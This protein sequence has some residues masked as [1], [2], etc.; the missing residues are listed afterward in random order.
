MGERKIEKTYCRMCGTICGIDVHVEDGKVVEIEGMEEHVA[1]R[2]RTCIKGSSGATWINLPQRLKKPLK[3]TENGFVEIE[4]EQA[5]DEIAER[6][7]AIQEQYGKRAI[8]VWKGEGIGFCQQEEL[9]RRFIHAIGSPNYFSNDTQCYAGRY[10]GF[11]LVYGTWPAADYD[12]SKLIVNWGT[13]APV[14]HSDWTQQMNKARANGGKFV[15]IDTKYNESARI[16]DLYLQPKPGTDGAL[17]WGVIRELIVRDAVNHDFI[18]KYTV[19]YEDLKAYAQSF[20]PEFVEAETGIKQEQLFALVELFI[21]QAP[22]I[23]SWVG[24][25]L[26]HQENGVNNT[27]V[28]TYIDALMGAIDI[29]GGMLCTEGFGPSHLELNDEIPLKHLEPIGADKHPVIYDMRGECDTLTLMDAI[30]TEKP[31]PMKGLILSAANPVLTNARAD[32][33]IDAFKQLDLLVVKDIM[34]TETAE[35]ADYV[36]P[37]ASYLE[38]EELHYQSTF[39]C[40]TLSKKVVDFGLQ[41]EYDFLKG[42][43]ERLGA[44]KYFPWADEHALNEWLVEPTGVS[45]ETIRQY[46]GGYNYKPITYKKYEVKAQKG[47]KSFNT[48]SGKIEFTSDYVASFGYDALAVYKRPRYLAEDNAFKYLLM[49]GARKHMYFHGRY[50]DIPQINRAC[51]EAEIEMH[52]VDAQA[53]GVV[54]GDRVRVTSRIGSLE[55][56]VLVLHEKEI[57]PGSVQ[58][59]HGW[60]D[61]NVNLIMP[62]DRRDPISGFPALKSVEVNIEKIS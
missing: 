16:S 33:V 15:T 60:K 58:I 18:N 49:T 17:A 23:T 32:K 25:G 42:L 4:L 62:D 11:N 31:Y 46:P 2:G 27:R 56:K 59:T 37:A 19:G 21:S 14:A 7:Q 35:L 55:I 13:N 57:H 28:A 24:T 22:H 26:E 29:K 36:L 9:Y 54:T 20:T 6:M 1:S 3:K 53:L 48:P 61:A 43:A 51:P 8:G 52:P 12:N 50:R 39:Q 38:R 41:N 34:M 40:V 47:E 10:I 44:G 5:M 45:L 30:L